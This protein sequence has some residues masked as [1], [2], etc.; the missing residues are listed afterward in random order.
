ME[1]SNPRTLY[2]DGVD[3]VDGER[4]LPIDD[5]IGGDEATIGHLPSL[6]LDVN[7][8]SANRC[9]RR[10]PFDP[11]QIEEDHVSSM[12]VS[13]GRAYPLS[14]VLQCAASTVPFMLPEA[15]RWLHR[16][17]SPAYTDVR[18]RCMYGIYKNTSPR[19]ASVAL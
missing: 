17:L 10:C 16:P 6:P 5:P 2:V 19:R 18:M 11:P 14:L 1:Q 4:G 7:A 9:E 3:G 12:S 8:G 15:S 13:L